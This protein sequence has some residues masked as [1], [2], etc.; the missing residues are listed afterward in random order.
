MMEKHH[1]LNCLSS[2]LIAAQSHS[3][4]VE[5]A[6]VTC[7]QPQTVKSTHI[8]MM[9]QRVCH[10]RSCALGCLWVVWTTPGE[11]SQHSPN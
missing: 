7:F 4:G 3:H 2:G 9:S 8:V 5:L 11:G 6:P 1:E 10:L